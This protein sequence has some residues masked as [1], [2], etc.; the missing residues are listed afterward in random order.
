MQTDPSVV[1]TL[2]VAREDQ[3]VLDLAPN[4]PL[5]LEETLVDLTLAEEKVAVDPSL[6][7]TTVP[8]TFTT[9]VVPEEPEVPVVV[10]P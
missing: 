8:S 6:V 3:T 7:Q 5:V 4:L 9:Q 1:S 2:L 10:V